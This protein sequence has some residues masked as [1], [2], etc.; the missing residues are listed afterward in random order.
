MCGN[1][2][3]DGWVRT[4]VLFFAV[5]GPKYN[6]L[7]SPVQNVRS[8]QRCFPTDNVLLRS[9]DIRDQVAKLCELALK[10]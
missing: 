9:G 2:Q 3:P 10:F 7:S 4:P 6:K 1:A 5:C 8:L